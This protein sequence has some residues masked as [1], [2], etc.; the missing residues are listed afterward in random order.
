[1]NATY[2]VIIVGA[3]NSQRF[4]SKKNKLLFKLTNNLTIIETTL[5]TFLNDQKCTQII[6]GV[7]DEIFAYLQPKYQRNQKVIFTTGGNERVDTIKNCLLNNK[8]INDIILIHD[9]ARC[10]LTN[11]FIDKMLGEFV[12][13][14]YETLIPLL[15][16]NDAIKKINDKEIV[17][18]VHRSE[19][20][21]VQT[22][23]MFKTSV[24][25]GVYQNYQKNPHKLSP[26]Y[27]DSQLVELYAS[28]ITIHYFP[29]NKDNIKVTYLEDII[30]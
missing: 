2:S 1:M 18:T 26:I 12:V 23:Q 5:Q 17:E 27:D 6:V 24:L 13:N 30:D 25:L 20:G 10:Y 14:N 29:G 21:L 11:D 4:Q 15:R 22:P 16:I 3:G 7:N 9:G 28:E 19:Y 8:I